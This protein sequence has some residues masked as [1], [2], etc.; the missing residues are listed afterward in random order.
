MKQYRI[1]ETVI[2]EDTG[3]LAFDSEG[4]LGIV[5]R[6]IEKGKLGTVDKLVLLS[7][8]DIELPREIID[9]ICES[10]A[11]QVKALRKYVNPTSI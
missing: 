2:L 5:C 4:S 7:N 3:F 6:K 1:S 10:I 11:I 9:G 8:S